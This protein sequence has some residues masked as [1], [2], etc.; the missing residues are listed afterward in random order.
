MTRTVR[1]A[2]IETRQA[3]SRLPVVDE[4]HWRSIAEGS[5]I[6][7][8]K[9]IRGGKWIGRFRGGRGAYVKKVLGAADDVVDADGVDF[10]SYRQAQDAAQAWFEE[11]RR[12]APPPTPEAPYTV[13]QAAA[14]YLDIYKGGQTKGGGKSLAATVATIE[15]FIRPAFGERAVST[16]TAED[17]RA[18]HRKLAESPPRKRGKAG[19]PVFRDVDM[20]DEDVIRQRRSSANRLLTVLK[21]I[22]NRVPQSK[23]GGN[24]HAWTEVTPF[25]EVDAPTVRW[26]EQGEAK[27]LLYASVPDL[28]RI[29]T[30]A[31]LTGARY[32]ELGRMK[33]RDFAA[34][35]RGVHIR[36]SKGQKPRFIHLTD[37]G[38]RFF[39]EQ[40]A[41][42]GSDELIFQREAEER[43]PDTKDVRQIM[44]PWKKSDQYRPIGDASEAAK[45]SPA[46]GFHILRHTYASWLAMKGVPLTVIARQLGHAD[47]RMTEKHY[48]HLA[49]SYVG[50]TVRAAFGDMGLAAPSNVVPIGA[51]AGPDAA[52]AAIIDDDEAARAIDQAVLGVVG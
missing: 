18:W 8:R 39:T 10:L 50:D 20:T 13:A 25:A 32:G 12:P 21:A 5:H 44:V 9:G 31:L 29:A 24:E 27:R 4:P 51:A 43:V 41:G 37:E 15:S 19:T 16:L 52:G 23:H 22:L 42:K 2:K 30:G 49:P 14:D 38:V 36:K 33:V 1:D 40:C 11:L 45:I 28:R 3:R 17:I 35:A 6:G 26:I 46:V 47:T 48:A 34:T 7:Y